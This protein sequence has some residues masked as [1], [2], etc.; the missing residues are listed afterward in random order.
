MIAL[1]LLLQDSSNAACVL[2]IFANVA[3]A[4]ILH[5]TVHDATIM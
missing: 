3:I 4:D 1:A 5:A 2:D